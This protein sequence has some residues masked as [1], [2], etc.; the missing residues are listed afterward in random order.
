[1][2]SMYEMAGFACGRTT[3]SLRV[4]VSTTHVMV[5]P[6]PAALSR[7]ELEKKLATDP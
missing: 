6:R 2:P 3:A 4:C 5:R 1:M 7:Q